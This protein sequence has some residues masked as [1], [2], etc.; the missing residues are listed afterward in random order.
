MNGRG[1]RAKGNMGGTCHFPTMSKIWTIRALGVLRLFL[2]DLKVFAPPL[3]TLNLFP[4]WKIYADHHDT[5][6]VCELGV[7]CIKMV[8]SSARHADLKIQIIPIL[9]TATL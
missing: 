2:G 7:I 9:Q 4:H 5:K 8:S 6:K 3:K 1:E